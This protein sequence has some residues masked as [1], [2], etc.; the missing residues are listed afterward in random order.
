MSKN[1]MHET[2]DDSLSKVLMQ[3]AINYI[4]SLNKLLIL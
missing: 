2:L 4:F 1:L 3:F